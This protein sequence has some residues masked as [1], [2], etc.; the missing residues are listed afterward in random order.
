MSRGALPIALGRDTSGRPVAFFD[1]PGGPQVPQTVIDALVTYLRRA[2][3]NHAGAFPPSRR[4]ITREMKRQG[5]VWIRIFP[6]LPVTSKPTEFRMGKGKCVV[7]ASLSVIVGSF[8]LLY[9]FII[10]GQAFPLSI[11]P[12]HSVTSTFADGQIATYIPSLPEILLGFG[13]LGIAFLITLV[14]VRVLDSL[15]HDAPSS[16]K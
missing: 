7:A 4:A 15:P 2:N 11:F 1:N 5:R 10:G 9:V 6:D 16:K 12:G 3:A 8:A 13:G 14:S